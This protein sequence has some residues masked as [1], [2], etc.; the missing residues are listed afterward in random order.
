MILWY[1]LYL[2]SLVLPISSERFDSGSSII[3]FSRSLSSISSVS[4]S[5]SGYSFSLE[6]LSK[7]LLF[8]WWCY[9][10]ILVELFSIVGNCDLHIM[11]LCYQFLERFG[12]VHLQCIQYIPL[13]ALSRHLDSRSFKK[14]IL[15]LWLRDLQWLMKSRTD[16]SF[17]CLVFVNSV[18]LTTHRVL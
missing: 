13:H 3:H 17:H 9:W 8:S 14:V 11:S 6:S 2:G 16:S 4:D 12:L 10:S 15:A 5:K 7:E 18:R 1:L